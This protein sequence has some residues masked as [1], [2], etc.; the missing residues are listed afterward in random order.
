MQQKPSQSQVLCVSLPVNT[1]V[2]TRS[3]QHFTAGSFIDSIKVLVS[4]L[5]VCVQL[6]QWHLI[7]KLIS[8][9]DEAIRF[10]CLQVIGSLTLVNIDWP[11]ELKTTLQWFSAINLEVSQLPS[12][13]CMLADASFLQRVLGCVLN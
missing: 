6:F 4:F 13:A 8:L 10:V 11:R 5:Q 1:D 2:P 9:V 12:L 7:C 3:N